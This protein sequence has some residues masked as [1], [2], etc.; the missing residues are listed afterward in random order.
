M[1]LT[2]LTAGFSS[3]GLLQGLGLDAKPADWD[4]ALSSDSWEPLIDQQ[5]ARMR[6]D[7]G[8]VEVHYVRDESSWRCSSVTLQLH[9][10]AGT[11]DEIVPPGLRDAVSR[12]E[13][14][15]ASADLL[16]CLDAHGVTHELIP[17]RKGS[18]EVRYWVPR[19]AVIVAAAA[20]GVIWSASASA[21]ADVWR[22][23][24]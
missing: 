11:Y 8:L 13:K 21:D 20:T 1:S 6:R 17:D 14:Q 18:G 2:W 5:A 24:L 10:L 7:Y 12:E 22:R 19:S 9:R 23:P 3:T 15:V 16:A 4:Q